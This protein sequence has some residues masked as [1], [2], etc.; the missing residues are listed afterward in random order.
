MNK[1]AVVFSSDVFIIGADEVEL[2]TSNGFKLGG[3]ASTEEE[4]NV[5][6][7]SFC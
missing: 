4:A 2:F 1:L 3:Y 7:E 6:A 5:L